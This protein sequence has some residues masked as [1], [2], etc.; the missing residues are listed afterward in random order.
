MEP[1]ITTAVKIKIVNPET[2]DS[3]LV[4]KHAQKIIDS[5][6][7]NWTLLKHMFKYYNPIIDYGGNATFYITY[8][9]PQSIELAKMEFMI[10]MAC[11]TYIMI[12]K[13]RYEV[14]IEIM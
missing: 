12:D 5:Y 10:S 9:L 14:K 3:L 6:T 2:H 4:D 7:D 1:T 8:E 13:K 11:S